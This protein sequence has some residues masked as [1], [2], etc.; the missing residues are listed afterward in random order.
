MLIIKMTAVVAVPKLPH[1]PQ[2]VLAQNGLFF[3]HF[4]SIGRFG[5]FFSSFRT[6]FSSFWTSCWD[7][8]LSDASSEPASPRRWPSFVLNRIHFL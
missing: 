7:L 4:E 8:C 2:W 3:P 1:L 5:T 6:L